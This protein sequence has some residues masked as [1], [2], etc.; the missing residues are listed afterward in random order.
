MTMVGKEVS[1]KG[2]SYQGYNKRNTPEHDEELTST[3]P[4]TVMGE[5]MRQFWQPVCLSE[6]LTDVPKAIRIMGENLVA[7]RDKQGKV[8]VLHRNCAHR[9]ASL[10]FGI[11]QEN[12]IRCCYHGWHFAVD[13]ELLDAPC[14]PEDTRLKQS[15][16]QGAY[17]AFERDGLV[18]AYFGNPEHIPAFPEYDSYS[19]PKGTKLVPF[20]NVYPCNWLQVHEN[21]MDH[22]HTAVLHN[23]MTVDGVDPEVAAGTTLQGF[24]DMPVMQW[25]PTRSNNGVMFIASRRLPQDRAWVRITEMNLPNYLQIGSLVP[26]AARE[27]HSTSGCTRWHVPVDDTHS[28]IFGWR[29]FNSEVDPDG[30]G[31]EEDCGVD[32]IDFLVGQTGNRSYEEAQ[33]A[34]G[35]WEALVS[36]RP[37]AIHAAENPGT[38]DVGVYMFRRLLREAARGKVAKDA[39]QQQW[40]QN[41]QSSSLYSQDS[42]IYLP[43]LAERAED[44]KQL[45]ALGKKVGDIMR[46]ADALPTAERDAHIRAQL[47]LLDDGVG[48]EVVNKNLEVQM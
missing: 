24:E 18:F 40:T 44:R 8:G 20:S 26:T 27:R 19:L 22:M 1:F 41:G 14:E 25:E 47:D 21:I 39:A 4:G 48:K 33:R 35:D 42:V 34:P 32:K 10:E 23:N 28:I 43:Q 17:P 7:F 36:Q 3:M 45:L 12:G 9:G 16:R 5:Y 46:S 29:H 6:E 15:V 37:I 2:R 38:S 31:C 11:I 30:M 13:G